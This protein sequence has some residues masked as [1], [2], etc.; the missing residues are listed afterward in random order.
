MKPLLAEHADESLLND[1]PYYVSPKIDG[2][3]NLAFEGIPRT[4]SMRPTDNNIIREFLSHP[5]FDGLDGELVVGQFDDPLAFQ[6]SSGALRRK[7]DDPGAWAWHIFDDFTD[8]SLPFSER[9]ERSRV[10]VESLRGLYPEL[11]E[12]L[13]HVEHVLVHS[14]E[15]LTAYEVWATEKGFEGVML[16]SRDGRY[17][18]GRSTLKESILLKLKRFEHDECVI[19]DFE[20]LMHNENEAYINE[21]GKTAR[22]THAENL[23]PSG[24]LGA[25]VCSSPKWPG[26][27][28]NVSATTMPHDMRRWAWEHRHRLGNRF[29]RGKHFSHGAKDRPRHMQWD[30]FREEWDMDTD[31]VKTLSALKLAKWAK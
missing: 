16:R 6:N 4:R 14:P 10:R 15:E 9:L 18:F 1:W 24:M 11:R 3:R 8:P 23:V 21:L 7:K 19:L 28:F 2:F 30:G 13:F 25:F 26:V 20:E 12:R 5:K 31:Q 27:E 17:K 29:L 22:S